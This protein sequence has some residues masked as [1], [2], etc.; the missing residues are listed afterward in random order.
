LGIFEEDPN[1]SLP[2]KGSS[3]RDDESLKGSDDANGS[4]LNGSSLP[5]GSDANA[6]PETLCSNVE[7]GKGSV[8]AKGSDLE[9]LNPKASLVGIVLALEPK[10][11]KSANA[12]LKSESPN[13]LDF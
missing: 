4:D 5:N 10:A 3:L 13:V 11:P 8:D 1:G 6:S 12:L 9:L 2:P 7:L